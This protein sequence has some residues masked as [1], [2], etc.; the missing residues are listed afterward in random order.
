MFPVCRPR[1]NRTT[2]G[3]DGAIKPRLEIENAKRLI[4]VFRLGDEIATGG[5]RRERVTKG[6]PGNA[7]DG[8][9]QLGC[10]QVGDVVDVIAL[11]TRAVESILVAH[12]VVTDIESVI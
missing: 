7:G 9:E 3:F 5:V 6:D 4:L 11:G 12:R 1:P 10:C 2:D 8:G